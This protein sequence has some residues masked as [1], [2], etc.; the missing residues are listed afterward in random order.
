MPVDSAD[1]LQ[2]SIIR[3][4]DNPS[5]LTYRVYFS[6]PLKDRELRVK[7]RLV[8]EEVKDKGLEEDE[9]EELLEEIPDR[10]AGCLYVTHESEVKAENWVEERMPANWAITDVEVYQDGAPREFP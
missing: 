6:R 5:G 8:E 4:R 10:T 9:K 2:E 1:V 3:E 7:E